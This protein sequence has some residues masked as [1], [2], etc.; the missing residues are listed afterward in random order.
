MFIIENI[1]ITEENNFLKTYRSRDMSDDAH[2]T[3]LLKK[4]P[5]LRASTS[6]SC[7]RRCF[8]ISSLTPAA[9]ESKRFLISS[10]LDFKRFIFL[11]HA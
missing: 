4:L 8:S 3:A 5:F 11:T 1:F 7:L 2:E 10:S 6:F 9:S